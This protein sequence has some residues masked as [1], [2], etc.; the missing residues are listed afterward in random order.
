MSSAMFIS[1]LPLWP[2]PAV[3]HRL[4][5]RCVPTTAASAPRRAVWG[6]AGPHRATRAR[7]TSAIQH[8]S[9]PAPRPTLPLCLPSTPLSVCPSSCYSPASWATARRSPAAAAGPRRRR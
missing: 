8:F 6:S 5:V 7:E 4:P 3:G 2:S 1:I 9:P